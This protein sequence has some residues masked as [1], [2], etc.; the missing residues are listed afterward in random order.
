MREVPD[1]DFRVRKQNGQV[2]V[3]GQ[4]EMQNVSC[5]SELLNK[6]QGVGLS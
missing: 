4:T 5:S 6:E 2:R 1:G 3:E